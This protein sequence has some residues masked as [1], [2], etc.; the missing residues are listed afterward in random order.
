MSNDSPQ[1]K[2][3]ILEGE[4]ALELW[5]K[6]AEA[7]NAWINNNPDW[8]I[9]F[10]DIDFSG[11]HDKDGM[12]SFA[13]YDFGEGDVS[14]ARTSFGEG[15]VTF[16]RAKF[17]GNE[18]SFREAN[19]GEGQIDFL[20]AEFGNSNVSFFHTTFR[21]EEVS[22]LGA[23]FGT[24]SIDFH[25]TDFGNSGVTFAGI[26]FGAGYVDFNEAI[27]GSGDVNFTHVVFGE[28]E[29]QFIDTTFGNC[30]VDFDGARFEQCN[31]DFSRAKFGDGFLNFNGATFDGGWVD[32][33]ETDFGTGLIDFTKS[34]FS[35][36]DLIFTK[37]RFGDGALVFN[38]VTAPALFFN[39]ETFQS[40]RIEAQGLTVTKLAIFALPECANTLRS[41]D[42]FGSSFD[43]PLFLTGKLNIIPDLRAT[44]SSNQVELSGLEVKLHGPS[45]KKKF[46]RCFSAISKDRKVSERLRRL[47]EIAESNKDHQAA[48]R[49]AADEN[50]ARRWTETSWLGSG[51]DL[52]FSGLSNYGQSIL[53]PF[54]WLG[55]FFALGVILYFASATEKCLGW[56]TTLKQ[57]A[58]LSISNSLAFLPQS[59][60]LRTA[61]L[62]RLYSGG[63]DFWVDSIMIGQGALSFIFLFLIGLGLRNRFRL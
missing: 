51:L 55:F 60:D 7:W 10:S 18:I 61:T 30:D 4:S 15:N 39:P 52:A 20:G 6:G 26:D 33:S 63:A 48:L 36:G 17:K 40:S 19:F 2:R 1:G 54:L 16:F 27:F 24:G 5:R 31:L 56:L 43:G 35:E 12:L 57:S 25:G 44:R 13:A 38:R 58:L 62:G 49:F 41:F 28:G 3:N 47:K 59:R 14:F 37:A 42:L 34:Q 50:R 8:Y 22:F 45:G 21:S 46:L 32:F 53:R 23:S 29:V 11:E 9:N